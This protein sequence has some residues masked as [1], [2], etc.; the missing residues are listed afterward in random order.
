MV[1]SKISNFNSAPIIKMKSYLSAQRKV[2]HNKATF[3]SSLAAMIISSIAVVG[4]L[5]GCSPQATEAP[6]EASNAEL[7]HHHW[8]ELDELHHLADNAHELAEDGSIVDLKAMLADL[9]DHAL[10]VANEDPPSFI[11]EP[12]TVKVL[13][14]DLAG[15]AE[16]LKNSETLSDE[17]IINLANSFHPL[18]EQIMEASGLSHDHGHDHDHDHDHDH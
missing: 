17:E 7:P 4:S 5:T 2:S 14:P 12:L 16:E 11:A 15:L 6:E 10:A 1:P 9:R 13:L 18:V 3:T 8:D